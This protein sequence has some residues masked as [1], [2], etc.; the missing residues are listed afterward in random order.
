MEREEFAGKFFN[1]SFQKFI[2]NNW[3]DFPS[4]IH[5]NNFSKKKFFI[6]AGV[7]HSRVNIFR[8]LSSCNN[9]AVN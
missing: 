3:Q 8:K 1:R 2:S 9:F 7:I 4:S 5:T 6:Q